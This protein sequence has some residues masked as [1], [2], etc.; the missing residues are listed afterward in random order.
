MR[1]KTDKEIRKNKS[2]DFA[3]Y[4]NHPRARV[5]IINIKK[6]AVLDL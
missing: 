1:G 4:W 2:K 5:I 3:K 6:N